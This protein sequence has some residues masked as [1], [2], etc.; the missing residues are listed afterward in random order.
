METIVL[1]PVPHG[2]LGRFEEELSE[3]VVGKQHAIFLPSGCMAQS[4]ALLLHQ[5]ESIV[6]S[7]CMYG[8][9]SLTHSLTHS[10]NNPSPFHPLALLPQLNTLK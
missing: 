9:A 1:L 6:K 7:E 5:Q 10:L 3:T 4:I 8:R 2:S